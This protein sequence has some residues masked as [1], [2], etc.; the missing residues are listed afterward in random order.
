MDITN[1]TVFIPGATSGI[2]LA[3]AQRLQAAGSTVVIGGRRQSLL[4]SL[5]AEHGFGT[6]QIDVS[7]AASIEAAA[8]SV[9]E[10]HPSLDTLVT[11]S[12]IMRNEDLRSPTT[13]TTRSRS[14]RPTWS[15]RSASS[16]RSCRTC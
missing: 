5:A 16:T 7:D 1:S 10:T 14:S 8:A 13:S 4:D 12:G 6:V 3:L 9:L 15:A 2:G 11:M